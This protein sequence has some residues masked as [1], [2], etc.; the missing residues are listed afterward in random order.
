MNSH[1]DLF[2]EDAKGP[3]WRESFADCDEARRKA[4]E[5][6]KTE[7]VECFVYSFKA[8]AIVERFRPP[9]PK[10]KEIRPRNASPTR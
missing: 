3:L 6:A 10:A 4:E 8:S 9:S 2:I 7:G 5:V 1:F